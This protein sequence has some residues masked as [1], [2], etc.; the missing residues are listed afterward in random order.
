MSGSS[1]G[2]ECEMI[3]TRLL[4]ISQSIL[5]E[6]RAHIDIIDPTAT[7]GSYIQNSHRLMLDVGSR[8]VS[9]D[10]RVETPDGQLHHLPSSR[11]LAAPEG[12][13][14]IAFIVNPSYLRESLR[15][16]ARRKQSLA[17]YVTGTMACMNGFMTLKAGNPIKLTGVRTPSGIALVAYDLRA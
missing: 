11:L 7:L 12:L 14:T 4:D 15:F 2:P 1:L 3:G 13:E 6:A 17:A 9:A 10:S 16:R 5:A 8:G